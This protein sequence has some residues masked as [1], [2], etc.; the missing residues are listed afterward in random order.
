MRCA[1]D[2]PRQRARAD[3]ALRTAC[4]KRDNELCEYDLDNEDEDWLAGYNLGGAKL[5]PERPCEK[6]SMRTRCAMGS[7]RR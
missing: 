3:A 7:S 5:P 4:F 1:T 2:S 6:I